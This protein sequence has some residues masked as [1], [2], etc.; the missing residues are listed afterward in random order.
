MF[1]IAIQAYSLSTAPPRQEGKEN[2]QLPI[3]K[4]DC[5]FVH[6]KKRP[7]LLLPGFKYDKSSQI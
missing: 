5:G 7:C 2:G 1:V 3:C 4:G 6:V